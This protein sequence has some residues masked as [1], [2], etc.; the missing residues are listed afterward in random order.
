MSIVW[1]G[2]LIAVLPLIFELVFVITLAFFQAQSDG[3]AEKEQH[4]SDIIAHVN[5]LI[6]FQ[7]QMMTSTL[8]YGI[9]QYTFLAD[10]VIETSNQLD[11]EGADLLERV[12]ADAEQEKNCRLLIELVH[13]NQRLGRN[14]ITAIRQRDSSSD[15]FEGTFWRNKLSDHRFF[16]QTTRIIRTEQN[17]RLKYPLQSRQAKAWIR[18]AVF[19]G[20]AGNILIGILI[21]VLFN[22]DISRR[23]KH[24]VSNT[25]LL[26]RERELLLP[27]A[28][29]DELAL[30]DGFLFKVSKNLQE[31]ARKE[32][33]LIDNTSDVICSIS[34]NLCFEKVS[35]VASAVWDKEPVS[36]RG[37]S[38]FSIVPEDKRAEIQK[39]LDGCRLG[40]AAHYSGT[41]EH[42][43]FQPERQDR[44]M[45]WTVSWSPAERSFFCVCRDVSKEHEIEVLKRDFMNMI[46][47]DL[48]SPLQS[49]SL[50][51]YMLSD[52]AHGQLVE[53]ARH[54]VNRANQSVERLVHLVDQLLEIEKL[55]A[56]KLELTSVTVNTDSIVFAAID[57]LSGLA[58]SK[59]INVEFKD[60]D[61]FIV[62]ADELRVVQVLQ[63]FIS[64][65]I[66]FS[67][68]SG[69]VRINT[70]LE[71]SYVRITVEDSGP[72][73][74]E[75][76]RA[77]VFEKFRQLKDGKNR[78]GT[79]LGLAIA[80]SII[81]QHGGSVGVDSSSDLGG[82]RFWL[83]L[84]LAHTNTTT[85]TED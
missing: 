46:S 38:I 45:K 63:N 30:L 5:A 26:D 24:I 37:E 16:D 17:R 22:Q 6:K 47:H 80:R 73:I 75:E 49:V 52:G 43:F 84:P 3:I 21:A 2:L 8:M 57:L 13:E 53:G 77:A 42:Q 67:P 40:G 71:E 62:F 1:K 41:F 72:G 55:D 83:R 9:S 59:G 28:G 33:V 66:K 48:R 60:N 11:R 31:N 4:S 27:I 70:L 61:D 58:Q 34:E 25:E 14:L 56:G 39:L 79:G 29:K 64:N 85:D 36:L 51:L 44:W 32:R 19:G 82:A 12:K 7:Y 76:M 78:Q 18:C 74:P 15:M 68:V 65:A 50:N 35:H 54:A 23:I 81:E 69:T 10:R 20:V